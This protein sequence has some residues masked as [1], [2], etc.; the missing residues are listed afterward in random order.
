MAERGSASDA[1]PRQ[2]ETAGAYVPKHQSRKRYDWWEPSDGNPY[3]DIPGDALDDGLENV[4]EGTGSAHPVRSL[5]D[6]GAADA[7]SRTEVV[8]P[9]QR[10]PEAVP[11]SRET[12]RTVMAPL[13]AR[14]ATYLDGAS[15]ERL[16]RA[17]QARRAHDDGMRPAYDRPDAHGAYRQPQPRRRGRRLPEIPRAKL[18]FWRWFRVLPIFAMILLAAASVVVNLGLFGINE[19]LYPLDYNEIV[20]SA[21]DAYGIDPLLVASVIRTE[22]GWDPEALSS[23]GARGLMQLLPQTAQELADAGLVDPNVYNPQNLGDP[24]TN[25]AYGTAYLNQCIQNTEDLDQAIAAYN[26]GVAQA[27]EWAAS[28]TPFEEAIQFPETT[29]YLERVT[30]AYDRYQR[31]Y[32]DGIPYEP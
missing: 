31:T 15:Q 9:T 29:A 6:E 27:K 28:D 3:L 18:H 14:P 22:S 11:P 23:A 19:M 1:G 5:P 7:P 24:A 25:I 20:T 13:P 21:A 26:A 16:R 2:G 12:Q 17:E 30:S 4:L 10:R 32:P 8:P